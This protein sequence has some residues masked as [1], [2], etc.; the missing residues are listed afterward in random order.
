[1][2]VPGWGPWASRARGGRPACPPSGPGLHAAVH[3]P[4]P[5]AFSVRPPPPLKP[6]RRTSLLPHLPTLA[7]AT[8]NLA[9]AARHTDRRKHLAMAHNAEAGGN[10]GG[11][12][13]RSLQLTYNEADIMYWQRI[14]MPLQFNLPHGWHLSNARYAVPPPPPGLETRALIAERRAHMSPADRSQPANTQNSPVWPRRFQ[15]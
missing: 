12:G 15:D 6:H 2:C 7:A 3:P 14:P 5:R 4:P 13:L 1:M 8:N 10:S 9:D 11:G